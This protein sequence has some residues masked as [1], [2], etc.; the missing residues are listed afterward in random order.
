MRTALHTLVN[1]RQKARA[2]QLF[3]TV[4]RLASGE[5]HDE[6]G[7]ILVHG[8]QSIKNP[9]PQRRLPETWVAGMHQ[10]LRRGVIELLGAHRLDEAKVINVFLEMGQAI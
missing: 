5:K 7:Q 6:T 1:A 3:A 4:R 2:P 8:A 9:R 10:Q